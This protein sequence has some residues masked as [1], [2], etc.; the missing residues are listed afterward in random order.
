MKICH[1]RPQLVFTFY[2]RWAL[3]QSVRYRI[4]RLQPSYLSATSHTGR[5]PCRVKSLK[6]FWLEQLNNKG[7]T[8]REHRQCCQAVLA[9]HYLISPSINSS[10]YPCPF[11][12]EAKTTFKFYFD[13][14]GERCSTSTITWENNSVLP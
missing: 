5:Q 6:R 3:P 13:R 14:H 2:N 11:L 7:R 1:A 12:F 9:V 4:F 8:K 10:P